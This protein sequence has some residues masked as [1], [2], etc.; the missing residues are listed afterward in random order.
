MLEI[1]LLTEFTGVDLL[2]A[3]LKALEAY[4]LYFYY[5]SKS[6]SKPLP[7]V[8]DPQQVADYFSC[9]PH[10]VTF[11]LLEVGNGCLIHSNLKKF[12]VYFL[13]CIDTD[14]LYFVLKVVSSFASAAIRIR[15]SGI[16]NYLRSSSGDAID[17]GL[18]QYNFGMVL[19]ETMLNLGPTFIKGVE[20][21]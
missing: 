13:E 2:V 14:L 12:L 1:H 4:A 18:S 10:V 16:K 21:Y 17:E 19:K 9:R 15:T 5:L 8:Y 11:R 20:G 6:W 7:E 3:D